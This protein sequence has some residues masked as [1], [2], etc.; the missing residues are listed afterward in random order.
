SLIAEGIASFAGVDRRFEDVGEAEGV[1]VIDDYAHH[2]TEVEATLRAAREVYPARRIVAIFQP[3]LYSRTRDFA[4][5]F[6]R[7]LALA[8]RVFVTDVYA[9]REAP[10]AGIT[11]EMIVDAAR[12]AG[13]EVRYIADRDDVADEVAAELTSGDVCL[14]LGAGNL[15]TAARGILAILGGATAA[16][17]R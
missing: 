6:G 2:P 12:A 4:A 11:G 13:A 5:E 8:D 10:I 1:R 15:D 3:H 17:A 7:A 16:G 14:T 9:A